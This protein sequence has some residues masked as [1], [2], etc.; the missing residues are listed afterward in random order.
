MTRNF[1]LLEE[2]WVL[3][4]A[5]QHGLRDIVEE[6]GERKRLEN[7]KGSPQSCVLFSFLLGHLVMEY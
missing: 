5:E 1:F 7:S 6:Q 3:D 4:L 2:P